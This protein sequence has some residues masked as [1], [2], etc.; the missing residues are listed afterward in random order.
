MDLEAFFSSLPREVLLR[1]VQLYVDAENDRDSLSE[2]SLTAR[3]SKALATT[4][5]EIFADR[6]WV[7]AQ[8]RKMPRTQH[9][10]LIALL[11]TNSVAGGT[12]LLQELTQSHGMSEDM[13]AE[14]LHA[15]G[16]SLWV[17]GN[18][19]QSPPLFYV[20]PAPLAAELTHQFGRRLDLR[21]STEDDG[22]RP[23]K[24]N[25]GATPTGFSLIALLTYLSQH[26]VRVTRQ[27]EI[28]KKNQEE[29]LEF[30]ANLWTDQPQ[31]R[32][33]TWYVDLIRELGLAR[34]RGGY[35]EVDDLA[36][37]EF[38][39]MTPTQRRDLQVA[40]FV[41]KEQLLRWLL[42]LLARL[43]TDRWVSIT[44]LRTLYRRRYMGTVFHRRYVRKSYYLPPSGF[45]DPDPP[46]ETL[47]LAGLIE[48]GVNSD[49]S[50][51]R[52]SQV[53]RAFVS[54]EG[55]A[56]LESSPGVQCIA[57]PTFQV[58][59][60]VGL[61]LDVLWSLGT[62]A[63]L[64]TADRASTYL[65]TRDSVR[66]ALSKGWRV[67]SLLSFLE[68]ASAVGL[69]Q[70]VRSTVRDWLGNE[71]EVE[72][73]DS[74]VVTCTPERRK[75]VET[76]LS[77]LDVPWEALAPTVFAIPR[78]RRDD[79]LKAMEQDGLSPA[80]GVRRHDLADSPGNLR[81]HLHAL[82]EDTADEPEEDEGSFPSKALVMLGAPSAE[83]GR[84]AMKQRGT[85]SGRTGSNAVG[86]DLSLSPAAAGA[87]DLLRLSP[88][89]TMSVVRAAIR[90]KLDL[91]VLYPATGD[92]DPGGLARVTP[93][94]VA[95]AGGSSFFSGH[96]HRL[97]KEVEFRINRINGI[98]LAT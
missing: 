60:P 10:A 62:L 95:E 41:G 19:H 94:S 53:G 11:Q 1:Y 73:H 72:F 18:S 14:E 86:A 13:W 96:H 48:T 7:R 57:Q 44:G 26:K 90:L 56:L 78:E 5:A 79:V 34:H 30:F 83:G 69:P 59:A 9:V 65:L 68:E 52:L 27:D 81:G 43:E 77:G 76:T 97:D 89:K 21:A 39:A 92:E 37:S 47:Q 54:G 55:L 46:L 29:L 67:D 91:E 36:I 6:H 28:F 24:E 84:E 20:I 61:A 70:N 17:F 4:L 50:F 33:L 8:L 31:E 87:G 25:S 66:Q 64:Q 51:L 40:F 93:L 58:L 35:L 98:R 75:A 42:D 38:L 49:E 88:A 23:G 3:R 22:I 71:G 32:L 74:L 2:D 80:E 82:L 45:Y 15:L 12:W 85:R 63:Q 16:T